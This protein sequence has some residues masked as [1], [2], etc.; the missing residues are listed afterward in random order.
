MCIFYL[1]VH[2]KIVEGSDTEDELEKEIR[3]LES[4]SKESLRSEVGELR[5]E[6]DELKVQCFI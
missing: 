4:K 2:Q 5:Q 3:A 1:I 6:L